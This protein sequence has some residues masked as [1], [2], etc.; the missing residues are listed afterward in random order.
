MSIVYLKDTPTH[1]KLGNRIKNQKSLEH[2]PKVLPNE[3][4]RGLKNPT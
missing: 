3:L 2:K 1:G 4:H